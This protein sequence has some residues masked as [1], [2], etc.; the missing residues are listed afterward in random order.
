MASYNIGS[1]TVYAIKKQKDQLWSCMALSENVKDLFKW[2]I[3][4]HLDKVLYKEMHKWNTPLII[5]AAQ[6]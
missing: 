2:Q 6:V 1:S 4:V 3:L 5:C